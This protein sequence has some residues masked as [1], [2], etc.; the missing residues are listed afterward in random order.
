MPI[1]TV[2]PATGETVRTF[3]AHD[4]AQVDAAPVRAAGT[5]HAWRRRPVGE[6]AAVV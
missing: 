2:N 4:D 5:A 3:D 1:A 6:R